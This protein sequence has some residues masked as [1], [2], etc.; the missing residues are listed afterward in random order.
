MDDWFYGIIWT[1]CRVLF[2]DA[3]TRAQ[4]PRAHTAC[5]PWR[6]FLFLACWSDRRI[7]C[8]T[9]RA[10]ASAWVTGS[11]SRVHGFVVCCQGLTV[12][13]S[14]TQFAARINSGVKPLG[15]HEF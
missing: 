9:Q 4:K 3:A 13:S 7:Y 11:R 5:V 14:R 1:G 8:P 2:V 10:M 6:S 15:N 12:H